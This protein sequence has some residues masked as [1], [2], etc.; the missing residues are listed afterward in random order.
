[1][2]K[3]DLVRL[4]P[5]VCFTT[6]NGGKRDYPLSN[7]FNDQNGTVDGFVKLTQEDRDRLRASG[8]Y[9]GIDS[10]GEPKLVPSEGLAKLKRDYIYQVLRARCAAVRNYRT[11]RGLALVLDTHTGRTVYVKRELLKVVE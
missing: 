4:N 2:R 7:H 3:N 10:G 11:V 8:R 6:R 1:M 9:D 5:A